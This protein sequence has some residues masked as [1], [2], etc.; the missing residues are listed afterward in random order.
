MIVSPYDQRFRG[1]ENGEAVVGAVYGDDGYASYG[2]EEGAL[3]A[4]TTRPPVLRPEHRSWQA[5]DFSCRHDGLSARSP[6]FPPP[7]SIR[8]TVWRLPPSPRL[9]SPGSR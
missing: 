7:R 6:P 9:S 5:D 4:V 2:S 8:P 3:P 1:A